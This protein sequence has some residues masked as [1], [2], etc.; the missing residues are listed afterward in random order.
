M[1]NNHID[2]VELLRALEISWV[3]KA[4]PKEKEESSPINF[5]RLT[6]DEVVKSMQEIVESSQPALVKV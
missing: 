1:H 6:P 2:P 4:H 3:S 5:S